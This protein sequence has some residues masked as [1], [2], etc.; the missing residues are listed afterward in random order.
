LRTEASPKMIDE[1]VNLKMKAIEAL[2][3]ALKKGSD[4][5]H[6]KSHLLESYGNLALASE[7][8][9]RDTVYKDYKRDFPVG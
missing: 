5:E 7:R 1:L 8:V 9:F 4:A 3:D 6:E 2:S